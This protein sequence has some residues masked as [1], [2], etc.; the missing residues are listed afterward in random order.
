MEF[1]CHIWAFDDLRLQEAL[2][3]IARLGFRYVDMGTGAHFNLAR[4]LDN[5]ERKAMFRELREQLDLFNLDVAD[6]VLFLP[7]ISLADEKK[8]NRDILLFRALLPFAKAFNASGV[9]VTSGLLHPESDDEAWQRM[10]AALQ[11]MLTIAQ[12][13]EIPL[14]VEP[15]LDSMVFTIERIHRL[16]D[17]ID[18][19]QLTLDWAHL[20]CQGIDQEAIMDLLPHTRHVQ[21]RQ[22]KKGKLQVPYDDGIIEADVVV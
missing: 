2:G 11:N 3:T 4:A 7:R 16:L 21:I 8:R 18:G 22:A 1:S 14:S 20:V 12:E 5:D 9:T 6:M 19:L 13:A 15:H 17:S 10:V